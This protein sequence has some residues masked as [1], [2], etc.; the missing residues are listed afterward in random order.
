MVIKLENPEMMV[1]KFK[2]I[3]AGGIFCKL[4]DVEPAT[5]IPY[6]QDRLMMKLYDTTYNAIKLNTGRFMQNDADTDCIE[7]EAS[8]TL[9]PM[10]CIK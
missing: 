7:Y 5:G 2:D 6:S 4:E 10:T 9:R 8:L 3:S 1:V